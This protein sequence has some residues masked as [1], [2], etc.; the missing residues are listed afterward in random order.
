MLNFGLMTYYQGNYFPYYLNTSTTTNTVTVFKSNSQI[1]QAHCWNASSGPAATCRINGITMTLR[2]TADSRYRI[3]RG[4]RTWVD[5]DVSY[6]GTE[7][8]IPGSLGEGHYTGSYYQYTVTTSSNSTS[9]ITRPTYSGQNIVYNNNNYSYY[10][11]LTNYY[12]GGTAPPIEFVDCDAGV[13]GTECGARWDTQLAP[14]LSTADDPT[15][16]ENAATAIGQAMAPAANGGLIFYWGTPTGCTLQNDRSQTIRT[17]AYHYMQAVKNGNLSEGIPADPVTCRDNYVLLIT[18]GAANGPGDDNCTSTAC[19]QPNPATAGC[20]CR[21]VL[22]AFN[23][24]QNLG[25]K[26]FVVGFS[27]DTNAG[28]PRIINDNIARAGGTDFGEDGVAP[29]AYLAQNEDELNTS[30][31]LVIYNAVRG[32]YSTAPTSTSAG[33]QQ[34]TTVAEGK[35]ALDSRMDFPEWKGHLLAYDLSGATPVLAWD[36]YQKLVATN[37]WERRIYT[38]NGTTMVPIT[39]DPVTHAVTNKEA[40]A[41]LGLGATPEEA[42]SV[43]RWL[44]GDPAYG[45][46][47]ILGAIIN[48]TPLDIASPGDIPEPGGHAFFLQNQNRP[49]LIYVGSSDGLLHA[50]FLENTQVGTTTYQAGTEAFA[51]L[52]PDMMPVVRRLY[53]QGGQKPDPYTHIFGM[54]DSPKAKTLCVQNCGDAATAVWK[55]V[56]L[57]PEG[58]GGSDTFM[59]D[60]SRPFATNGLANPPIQ[61]LWHTNY[62]NSQSTYDGLLGNTISLPAFFFNKTDTMADYRVIFTS[63]YPVTPGSTTQGRSLLTV[64]AGTGAILSSQSVAPT[65][66]CSQEYA[67]LTD[68]ATARDF[69]RGQS[70]RLLASYFGDT[71]GQLWRMVLGQ[72]PTIAQ[73][74]TCNHP[75][76]FSPTVVQLDR[77]TLTTSYARQIF[78]IQ[79]TNSNLDLDTSAFPPSKIIIWK[80][81][82]N[83][84]ATGNL[85]SVTSDSSW[86]AGGQI[87]LTVGNDNEICGVTHT[88]EHGV[89]TCQTAMPLAARPT[90]TPLG[91]LLKDGLGFQFLTMWYVPAPDGCTRGKTYLTIHQ[92]MGNG[93]AKQRLGIHAADEPVTS[94]VIVGGRVYL[95]GSSGAL[96]VTQLIPDALVAGRAVVPT[97]TIGHFGRFSWTEVF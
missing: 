52:P 20:T 70:N 35:Y 32:S 2:S 6:C 46:P 86:G 93:E 94:P 15:L 30:L 63:G 75:L 62:G 12:N 4:W 65:A 40:L 5:V 76:H 60:V 73:N 82:A 41:A 57:M 92:I 90:S 81:V 23:L 83:M 44:M 59:L 87:T 38:W 19:A 43:T 29:F 7:C 1:A 24:K 69:A 64:S 10:R 88:D 8:E 68:V 49:H 66:S 27:G 74:F 89:V 67:A 31:Q 28:T 25:V 9:M 55:T 50:F 58:Y 39:V 17:S 3:R 36:A 78:P 21:S 16:S 96:E 51:F 84:D 85:T 42:E 72:S 11:P 61:V 48:S 22:A 80:E 95:F 91:V 18:D 54:A 47:A 53:S 77:D 26:T 34:A 14:F 56:L 33:T 97:S 45:N 37:W 79:A 71:A 13:C